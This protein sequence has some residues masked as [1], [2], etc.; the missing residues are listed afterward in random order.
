MRAFWELFRDTILEIQSKRE[1]HEMAKEKQNPD[2]SK[3]STEM[4][5]TEKS[6]DTVTRYF[7]FTKSVFSTGGEGY[8]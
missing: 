6:E 4:K 7:T 2:Y 3:S 1:K 8:E 5:N